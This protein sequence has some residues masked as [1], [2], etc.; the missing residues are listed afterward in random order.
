[1]RK[2]GSSDF[3]KAIKNANNL[4]AMCEASR[5]SHKDEVR[6]SFLWCI[7]HVFENLNI[8]FCNVCGCGH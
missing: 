2:E 1:M 7:M 6:S 8:V 5:L 4:N 3:E